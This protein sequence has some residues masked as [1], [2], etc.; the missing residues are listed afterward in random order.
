MVLFLFFHWCSSSVGGFPVGAPR[1]LSR[2]SLFGFRHPH[3]GFHSSG[4]VGPY[5]YLLAMLPKILLLY[6]R[7][8]RHVGLHSTSLAIHVCDF[9]PTSNAT[10][11]PFLCLAFLGTTATFQQQNKGGGDNLGKIEYLKTLTLE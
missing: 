11:Q 1:A 8:R 9:L 5:P 3:P 2:L 6:F 10:T 4:R 7:R